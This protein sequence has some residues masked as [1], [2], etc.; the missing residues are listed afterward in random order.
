MLLYYITDRRTCPGPL[1]RG[2]Q[3]ALR[4]G[5]DMVQIREKDLEARELLALAR[6]SS[7][8]GPG[9][10]LINSRAD[11]ALAAG[12]GGVHLPSSG[13][14]PSLVRSIVPPGFLIG[15]SCHSGD[16]V[17]AAEQ[18]GADFVVFG[19]VFDTPSKRA[20]GPPQ[21]LEKLGEA[22]RAVRLPVLALGGISRD[23]V[24]SCLDRGA[25]GIAGISLF[26]GGEPVAETIAALRAAGASG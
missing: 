23:R 1:E 16:E 22:C 18:E 25:A 3:E 21:G 4:A 26:Q 14:A 20:Y 24:R 7:S 11:V 13:P 12:A 15:V 9:K 17:R 10:L 6:A 19:P 8:P 2:V 5:I